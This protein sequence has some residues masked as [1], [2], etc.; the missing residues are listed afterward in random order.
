[1]KV[2]DLNIVIRD[3]KPDNIMSDLNINKTRYSEN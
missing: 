2:H 1:M 3:I